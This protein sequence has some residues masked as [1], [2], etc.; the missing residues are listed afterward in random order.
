ML[1]LTISGSASD[2]RG[3]SVAGAVS[4]VH[5]ASATDCDTGNTLVEG[6]SEASA[7]CTT[8]TIDWAKTMAMRQILQCMPSH[9]LL[10]KEPQEG[11]LQEIQPY[12]FCAAYGGEMM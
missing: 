8:L 12:E 2:Q 3:I 9:L 6:V 10:P 7:L 11:A 5:A 4:G 1:N